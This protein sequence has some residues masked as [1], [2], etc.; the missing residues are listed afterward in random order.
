MAKQYKYIIA[1]GGL[2]GASAIEGIREFDKDGLILLVGK[3]KFLPYHRPPIS[4]SLWFGKKKPQDVFV[5]DENYYV[6]NGVDVLLGIGVTKIDARDS[7]IICESGESY[8][9]EKLL[10]ATGGIPRRLNIPGGNSEAIFYYRDLAD[11]HRL[12]A[13]VHESTTVLVI[14]GGFI[15]SEMAAALNHAG[16][17]VTLL[18][19]DEYMVKRVFPESLGRF[20]EQD[21]VNKGVRSSAATGQSGSSRRTADALRT[22]KTARG[23]NPILS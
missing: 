8:K 6:G 13:L 14:G 16:G 21:Y 18:Q 11:Y 7:T 23:L 2:A 10:I 5:Y 3:E 17:K 22:P 4:K 1:G 20:I 12:K 15:G 9:F 19:R